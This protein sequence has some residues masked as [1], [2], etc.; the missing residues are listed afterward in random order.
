MVS[1]LPAKTN[2]ADGVQGAAAGFWL[3][4]E[5]MSTAQHCLEDERQKK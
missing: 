3:F 4:S 1:L 2:Q 5:G